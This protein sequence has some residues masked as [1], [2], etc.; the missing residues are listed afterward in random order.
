MKD[1]KDT[2]L[3]LV[4]KWIRD[5]KIAQA[6][7]ISQGYMSDDEFDALVRREKGITWTVHKSETKPAIEAVTEQS[8]MPV[9]ED[10]LADTSTM[11]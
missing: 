6:R 8:E 11:K 5:G 1:E 4:I 9:E 3:Q 10:D 2:G 7:F